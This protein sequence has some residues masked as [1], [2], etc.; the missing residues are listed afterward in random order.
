MFSDQSLRIAWATWSPGTVISSP[1]FSPELAMTAAGSARVIPFNGN[2]EDL[3]DF[4]RLRTLR[5]QRRKG[6]QDKSCQ[7]QQTLFHIMV[8]LRS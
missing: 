6:E 7:H 3:E 4:L 1:T 5:N 8:L 2:A